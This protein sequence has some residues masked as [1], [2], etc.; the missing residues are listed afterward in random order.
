[1]NNSIDKLDQKLAGL[2]GMLNRGEVWSTVPEVV[3]LAF[4]EATDLLREQNLALK[5]MGLEINRLKMQDKMQNPVSTTA[6]KIYL[7]RRGGDPNILDQLSSLQRITNSR[8][9]SNNFRADIVNSKN[10]E[11]GLNAEVLYPGLVDEKFKN[12]DPSPTKESEYLNTNRMAERSAIFGKVENPVEVC[13]EEKARSPTKERGI[14]GV[15]RGKDTTKSK[16]VRFAEEDDVHVYTAASDCSLDRRRRGKS[17]KDSDKELVFV[18]ENE[19]GKCEGEDCAEDDQERGL[20]SSFEQVKKSK[21]SVQFNAEDDVRVIY[22]CFDSSES[23][24]SVDR[25]ALDSQLMVEESSERERMFNDYLEGL[26]DN[27]SIGRPN[28]GSFSDEPNEM[29]PQGGSFPWKEKAFC[30]QGGDSCS[31]LIDSALNANAKR[32]LKIPTGKRLLRV[33]MRKKSK[34]KERDMS[35]SEVFETSNSDEEDDEVDIPPEVA[36]LISAL[37]GT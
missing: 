30:S 26:M 36:N 28:C 9:K 32:N 20:R 34:P 6:E 8:Q 31:P 2:V 14:L 10:S 5:E 11:L 19:S 3:M 27:S 12:D 17:G 16:G 22:D 4:I 21:K 7:N 23:P 33:F 1:M 13:M 37:A 15:K 18:F 35:G 29:T 24:G 25:R